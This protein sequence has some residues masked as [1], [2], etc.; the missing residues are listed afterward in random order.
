MLGKEELKRLHPY[1]HVD[2]IEGGVWV[3]EDAVA[4]P[5]AI[6]DTLAILAKKGGARYIEN[7]T[8]EEVLTEN[9]AVKSVKTNRGNVTCEYFINCA[10]MV[11]TFFHGSRH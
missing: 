6:C 7:C 8:V 10:G 2:D 9:G 1:L 11:T 4:N 3:P 5:K